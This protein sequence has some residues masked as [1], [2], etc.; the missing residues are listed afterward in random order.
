MPCRYCFCT[1]DACNAFPAPATGAQCYRMLNL[2]LTHSC[3]YCETS[4][5]ESTRVLCVSVV[6][7]ATINYLVA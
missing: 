7:A 1:R 5:G 3:A 4:G 6:L 2:R